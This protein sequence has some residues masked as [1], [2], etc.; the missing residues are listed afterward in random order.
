MSQGPI[1]CHIC[2]RAVWCLRD[3]HGNWWCKDDFLNQ[4]PDNTP[5]LWE[6]LNQEAKE[7]RMQQKSQGGQH[8]TKKAPEAK[9]CKYG[10]GS[11]LIWDYKLEGPNKFKDVN[12][13]VQ[14]SY[15]ICADILKSQGKKM[16]K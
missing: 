4:S 16:V 11:I 6:Q 13:G 14:H 15:Q 2:N 12:T 8:Y 3:N 1:T 9:P 5:E 10:C 7:A